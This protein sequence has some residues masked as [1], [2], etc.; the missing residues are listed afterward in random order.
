MPATEGERGGRWAGNRAAC[1][2]RPMSVRFA[3]LVL[4][5]VVSTSLVAC[6]NSEPSGPDGLF[7]PMVP[8]QSAYPGRPVCRPA[9]GALGGAG[10][11]GK[12]SRL[13]L[14]PAGYTERTAPDGRTQVLDEDSTVVGT[15]G[16]KVTLGGGYVGA[17]FDTR[18]NQRTPDA[19]GHHRCS[20]RP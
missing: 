11:G 10:F 12:G 2:I 17:S 6:S 14:W 1:T 16:E 4:C 7:F 3:A 20:I 15:V 8:R 18:T 5:F 13:P 19:C 9:R